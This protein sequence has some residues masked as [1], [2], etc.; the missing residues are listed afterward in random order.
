MMLSSTVTSPMELKVF[1]T[2]TRL[3]TQIKLNTL[4]ISMIRTKLWSIGLWILNWPASRI[5]TSLSRGLTS[6][7]VS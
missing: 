2:Q 1:V 4:T 3:A 7:L 6:L 5:P